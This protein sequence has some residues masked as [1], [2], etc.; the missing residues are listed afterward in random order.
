MP[1]AP[2]NRKRVVIV[3]GGFGGAYCARELEG[4]SSHDS[5]E[6]VLIDRRNYLVFYP[7]LAEAGTGNLEPRHVV[8]PIRSFL[9]STRFIMGEV[10]DISLDAQRLTYRIAATGEQREL[11]YDHLVLSPGSVTKL[12][13]VPGLEEHAF[14]MKSLGDAVTLRDRA[15]ALLEAA[16]CESSAEKRRELLHF[17]VVGAN[18]T[19]VEVAGEYDQFLRRATRYYGNLRPEDVSVSLVEQKKRILPAL[20]EDLA[21]YARHHLE[22]RGVSILLENSIDSIGAHASRLSSGEEIRARTIVWCAGIAPSPVLDRAPGIPRD[23]H[24]YVQ[25]E[26]DLS[27][28]GHDEVWSIGD[29]AVNRDAEGKPYPP[30]AQ[31][32]MRQGRHVAQNIKRVTGSRGS[33]E[34]FDYESAGELVALGCRSAVAKI[35][36]VKF[37]GF[38]AWWFYRTLYLAKMP[39]LGR[40]ARV[41]T[42]WTLSLLTRPD[43]VQLGVLQ[44][45]PGEETPS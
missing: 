40:K 17:V 5:L 36:G 20:D 18:F 3:G 31:H 30:T 32:A 8:V 22:S 15:V 19:G 1:D 24:G 43:V 2:G 27:V 13:D 45:E 16:D 38:I 12:P 9:R 37:S 41:A 28:V 44:R 7:L 11:G 21:K 39:G 10:R 35:L 26:R 25:C 33:P 6:V 42:D 23:E 34:P 4:S 29:V 14:E